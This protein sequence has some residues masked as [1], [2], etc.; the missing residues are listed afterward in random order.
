MAKLFFFLSFP[1]SNTYIL[2]YFKPGAPG[3]LGDFPC[4]RAQRTVH[5]IKG[6][7]PSIVWA[8]VMAPKTPS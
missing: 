8:V 4:C 2:F 6:G 5:R 3:V 1:S 7:K